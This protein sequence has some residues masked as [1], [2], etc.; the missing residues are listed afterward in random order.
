LEIQFRSIHLHHSIRLILVQQIEMS[1]VVV[2]VVEMVFFVVANVIVHV[3]FLQLL[4][5]LYIDCRHNLIGMRCN[6]RYPQCHRDLGVVVVVVVVFDVLVFDVQVCP[7]V[8]LMFSCFL[9]EYH[10]QIIKFL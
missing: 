7:M 1:F 8:V 4:E 9:M 3:D 10:L 2:G 6:L 5:M